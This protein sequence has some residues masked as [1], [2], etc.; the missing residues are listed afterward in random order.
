VTRLLGLEF[1]DLDLA[2]VTAALAARPAEA[3][4]AYLVTPNAD[5]LVRLHRDPECYGPLYGSADWCLLDSR[6]VGRIARILGLRTP[7]VVPGSDLTARLFSSVVRPDDRIALL[8]G[9]AETAA[10]LRSRFGLRRLLHHAPPMGFDQN[11]RAFAEAVEFLEGAAARF[12]FLAV[13]SPR[14]ELV[15]RA[16][17]ARGIARGTALCIGA[18]VLFLSGEE[19][20]A[21]RLV[22]RAGCEWAWRL[23]RNPRRMARRYLVEDP[24]ILRLLW[25]ERLALRG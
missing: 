13:G 2:G 9:T 12:S 11:P 16:L 6:V 15:A 3:P 5:H 4:F 7:P 21:P 19:R 24:A 14:Q 23:A 20:R 18:S 8:G 22:Q 1:D 17:A 10:A 25:R